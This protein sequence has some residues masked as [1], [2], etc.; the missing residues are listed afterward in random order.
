MLGSAPVLS[1]S[2]PHCSVLTLGG[3]CSSEYRTHIDG[4][5]SIDT[6]QLPAGDTCDEAYQ[7]QAPSWFHPSSACVKENYVATYTRFVIRHPDYAQHRHRRLDYR[8]PVRRPSRALTCTGTHGRGG[9]GP[10]E[11][12]PDTMDEPKEAAPNGQ[13]GRARDRAPKERAEVRERRTLCASL[14]PLCSSLSLDPLT[15]REI[16]PVDLAAIRVAAPACAAPNAHEL[17]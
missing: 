5:R 9:T 8:P 10:R 1:E 3:S 12:R 15:G 17:E 6:S 7:V 16:A 4:L 13:A 11:V 2:T 14:E